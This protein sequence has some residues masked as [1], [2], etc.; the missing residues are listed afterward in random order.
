MAKWL[1]NVLK[2]LIAVLYTECSGMSPTTTKRE[3]HDE[4]KIQPASFYSVVLPL[5]NKTFEKRELC[6]P[7]NVFTG[8]CHGIYYVGDALWHSTECM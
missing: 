6:L 5:L 8:F 2:P 3:R 1:L 4:H 7:T